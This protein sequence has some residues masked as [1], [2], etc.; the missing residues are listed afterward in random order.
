MV[1]GMS[2][3]ACW[4]G[5]RNFFLNPD[6]EAVGLVNIARARLNSGHSVERRRSGRVKLDEITG[7]VPRS[8]RTDVVDPD[9][10]RKAPSVGQEVD[11]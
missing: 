8:G 4:C 2:F 10:E 9:G 11:P 1:S 3:S 6:H 7:R 5:F